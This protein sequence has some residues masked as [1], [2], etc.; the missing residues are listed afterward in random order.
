MK[1][2]KSSETSPVTLHLID[3]NFGPE[4][5]PGTDIQLMKN[6]SSE[7]IAILLVA[8]RHDGGQSYICPWDPVNQSFN[9][10]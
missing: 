9:P 4:G 7:N 2:N 10:P 3:N 6:S 8:G 1:L 5:L